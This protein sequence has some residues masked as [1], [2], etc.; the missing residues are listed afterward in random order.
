M[1]PYKK[2]NFCSGPAHLPK[3]VLEQAVEGIKELENTGLSVLEIYHRDKRYLNL[4]QEAQELVKELGGLKNNQKVLFLHGG[5][6]H[7]FD[8]VPAN[9]LSQDSYAAYIDT[10]RWAE[11]AAQNASIYGGIKT[12]ASS[13]HD[14]YRYIPKTLDVSQEAAYLHLTSNNTVVGTQFQSIP[15]VEVP[16]VADMS[17]DIFSCTRGFSQFDL[18]Y[19][20]AQK[21]IGIAGMTLVILNEELNFPVRK[22]GRMMDL[23]QHL[24]AHSNLNTPPVFA[25]YVCLLMLRWIKSIGLEKLE[26]INRQ[27]ADLFYDELDRNALF[28]A[29][30]NTG[31]R[32]KMNATFF[33][34]RPEDEQ[35]FL[36][37]CEE[38]GVEQIKG[39]RS[40]GG[41][42][43]ALYN[44]IP[45]HWVEDLVD[46]MKSFEQRYG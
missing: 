5:A 29:Y 15:K 27:K 46:L 42:R 32:S 20:S 16:L 13:K 9:L 12:I 21:N 8:M 25:I 43:I 38:A 37:V 2:R 22:L 23:R 36:K 10:G 40:L 30:A 26:Q 4:L 31:S 41:L 34:N 24:K 7:M 17:S 14:A 35:R 45:L 11:M 33:C 3:Q 1:I 18:A 19:A 28:Q 39:H 6:K 44:A